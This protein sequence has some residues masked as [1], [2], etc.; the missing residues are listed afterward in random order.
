MG[1]SGAVWCK[2]VGGYQTRC[3]GIVAS[4]ALNHNY[5][6]SLTS[7]KGYVV[8]YQCRYRSALAAK[9]SHPIHQNVYNSKDTWRLGDSASMVYLAEA[10]D[11]GLN[12]GTDREQSYS[13][14]TLYSCWWWV[15]HLYVD[16][17]DI[18]H[19]LHGQNFWR[20]KFTP[21]S[22]NFLRKICRKCLFFA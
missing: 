20:I 1:S 11:T 9:K 13:Q 8:N 5:A 17:P 19:F 14:V 3:A 18:C 6:E 22:A 10:F 2:D 7:Y 12:L 4:I 16:I 15:L 21:K